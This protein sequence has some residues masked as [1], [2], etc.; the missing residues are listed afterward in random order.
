[1]E[2]A[3]RP[4]IMVE[5]VNVWHFCGQGCFEV[6]CLNMPEEIEEINSHVEGGEWPCP[7]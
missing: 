2:I 6:F 4:I 7:F 5:G 1:M 3:G